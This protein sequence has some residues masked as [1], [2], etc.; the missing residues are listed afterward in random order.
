MEEK[1][2]YSEAFAE[3]QQIVTELESGD[4]GI[5]LLSEKVKRAAVLIKI[6]R[7][8]LYTTSEDISKILQEL[9]ES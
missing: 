4:T 8:K 5:D 2:N 9:E 7:E 6:C 1:I 3:L